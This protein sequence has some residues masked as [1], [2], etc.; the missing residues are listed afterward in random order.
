MGQTK[1]SLAVKDKTLLR[2]HYMKMKK[3]IFC[4]YYDVNVAPVFPQMK[5]LL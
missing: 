3:F 4:Y 2:E 1:K 5:L